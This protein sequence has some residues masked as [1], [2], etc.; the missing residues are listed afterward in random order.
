MNYLKS[1]VT[2]GQCGYGMSAVGDGQSTDGSDLIIKAVDKNDPRPIW[3]SIW[4]G[5]NTLA[6]ALWDIKNKRNQYQVDEFLSK[7]RVF[8]LCG[9]DDSGAWACHEFNGDGKQRLSWIRASENWKAFTYDINGRFCDARGG[10]E[11]VILIPWYDENVQSNHGP[12]GALYPDAKYT[13]EGDT[14]SF[15]HL[16]PP[17]LTETEHPDYGGW[18]GRYIWIEMQRFNYVVSAGLGAPS[19]F[20]IDEQKYAPFWMFNEVN[21]H[22]QYNSETYDNSYCSIFRWREAYQND[23]EA[24]MDWCVNEYANANHNPKLVVNGDKTTNVV[25]NEVTIGETLNLDASGSFDPDGD[26]LTYKWWVYPEPGNY[27]GTLAIENASSQTA[28]I[29]IPLDAIDKTIHVILE[30]TDNGM[31]RLYSFRRIVITGKKDVT[32]YR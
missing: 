3:I 6:Q 23:F 30:V 8:E 14:P 32:S 4:G 19:Y 22:W 17:G 18:G 25:Y 24:R 31:P 11:S 28:K 9:Q 21:D 2:V 26:E 15:L 7:L 27:E 1:V 16:L 5:A 10:N 29:N 12:L 20:N 13:Y